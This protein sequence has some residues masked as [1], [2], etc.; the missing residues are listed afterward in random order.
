MGSVGDC[1][2]DAVCETFHASLKKGWRVAGC[3][4]PR[5]RP[6]AARDR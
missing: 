5:L 6:P 4:C 1:Y 3:G 2:D